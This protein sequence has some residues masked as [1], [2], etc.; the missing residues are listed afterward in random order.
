MFGVDA[1]LPLAFIT[2]GGDQ[3]Q[4]P[5]LF[6]EGAYSK[7]TPDFYNTPA[8]T[9]SAAVVGLRLKL[10]Q[11]TATLQYQAVG[12]NFI[13]GAPLR[14]FGPAP[15]TF[16][17]WRGNYF[18]SSSASRTTWRSTRS[19]TARSAR[20]RAPAAANT[21]IYPVFNP[22]VASGPSFFSAFAPNTQGFTLNVTAPVRVGETTRQ[23]ARRWRSTSTEMTPN[24]FG[25][26]AYGPGFASGHQAQARQARGRRCSSACRCSARTS[27]ST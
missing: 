12:A 22:F 6:G 7:Y 23:R 1:Q 13:D 4:H 27:R 21:Y 18:P 14:Y 19:S 15:S 2:L 26:L 24:G 17:F 25:Q 10:Y 16:G 3:T 5:V 11:A 9:D 20:R 8:V